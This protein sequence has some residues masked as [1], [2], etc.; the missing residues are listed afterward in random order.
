VRLVLELLGVEDYG[1]YAV[2]GS[3]VTML[4]F[5]SATMASATQRFFSFALGRNDQEKLKK[6][7]STNLII[8]G[9]IALSGFILLETV[10]LWYVENQ[11]NL[12]EERFEA[13]R[14][15]Y[16]FSVLTFVFT[17]ILTPFLS[18]IIAHEDMQI[19]AYVSILEAVMKLS[20]VF[21][22]IYISWDKLELY[23]VL[24]FI[25]SAVFCITYI[26]ICSK[27]YLECQF[28]KFYW[29][30][31]LARE[32]LGFTGWTLFGA[33]TTVG[34]NQAITILLNQ[35]FNPA[36][37]AARAIS[38]SITNQIIVFS[39]NFNVGLYPPIIKSYSSGD[40]QGM[41]SL[42]SNGSKITFFLMWVLALPLFI[43][44]DVILSLWLKNPPAEAVLF[45]RLALIEAV[46]NSISLPIATAARAPGKMK[47]YE[48][49]LGS[50][51]VLIFVVVWGILEMGGAAYYVYFVA[52]AANII[53][54][55]ARLLIV[56]K[57]IGLPLKP[58]IYKVFFPL[59]GVML[60]SLLP[61]VAVYSLLS[62][63]FISS[64]ISIFTCIVSSSVSMYYLGLDKLWR[65]KVRNMIANKINKVL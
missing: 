53:M 34:R 39:A 42:I 3:L 65:A 60:L 28:R 17:I 9:C 6:L 26:I 5:L 36:T 24:L 32:V 2:I 44:M 51:Q 64:A 41:F 21:L 35:F 59:L 63:N 7:F 20:T 1:I 23:G 10:G 8:Y 16:H 37:V 38:N 14:F 47:L 46:I 25:I 49:T 52:I 19:Y 12:P 40:K 58:Y 54:F 33:V 13:A 4:S 27:K 45:T 61:S 50:I 62:D 29:D 22:L 31:E 18:I 15:L 30:K 43:Q 11:L 55:V 56:K 57:L 48:L